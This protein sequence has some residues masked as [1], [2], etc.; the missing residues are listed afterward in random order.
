MIIFSSFLISK[1]IL[2]LKKM[3]ILFLFF[4]GIKKL[5]EKTE[6]WKRERKMF[7]ATE[8]RVFFLP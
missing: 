3:N 4:I 7:S 5:G 8:K 6:N 1:N 2:K